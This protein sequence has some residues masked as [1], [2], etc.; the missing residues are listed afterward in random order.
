MNALHFFLATARRSNRTGI[1]QLLTVLGITAGLLGCA[2]KNESQEDDNEEGYPLIGVVQSVDAER[3]QMTVAHEE[4]PGFMEPM[5][6]VFR[7]GAGD[8]KVVE[9][10][11]R[12]K[13][14]LVRDEDGGFRLTKIWPI[15]DRAAKEMR[16]V[17]KRLAK[18]AEALGSGYYLA[19]GDSLPD[20]ALLDQ[21]GEVVKPED[22]EGKAFMIN[23]IFTRC[24]DAK[25]CPL[26]T[27]KMARLQKMAQEAGLSNLEFISVTLDP[28]FDTPGVLHSYMEAYGID[29]QNFRFVTGEKAAVYQLIRSMGVTNIQDGEENIIHSL[30]TSLV[31][32]DRKIVMRSTKSAW[33]PE[34]FLE[35]AKAL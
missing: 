22:Y 11:M 9:P 21:F 20:F 24:T 10:E 27:S 6:M 28:K 29:G 16:E 14:R 31:G 35:A 32:P 7:V 25:M 34:A 26:S 23:F 4:I 19:E 15:D 1:L 5:T 30:A 3:L 18:Q 12:I 2:Q 8:I 33:E 13:A 17:N